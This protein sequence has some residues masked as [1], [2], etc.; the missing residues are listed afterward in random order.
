MNPDPGTLRL[1]P[2]EAPELPLVVEIPS[3]GL[4]LGRD[5]ACQLALDGRLYPQVSHLHARV[6]LE[7]ERLFIED[8]HS[9]NGITL[10]GKAVKKAALKAGDLIQL[11]PGGPRFLVVGDSPL[12]ET[13]FVKSPATRSTS[14]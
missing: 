9:R 6:G 5:P 1:R 11:G 2:I 8:L 3:G 10:N 7:R 12:T 14:K 4:T 13:A